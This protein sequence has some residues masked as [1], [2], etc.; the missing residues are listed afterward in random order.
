MPK[1]ISSTDLRNGYNEVS[2]WCHHTNEPAFVTKNGAGDLAVMSMAAYDEMQMRLSLYDFIETG[3]KDV[4]ARH[5]V[6]AR[7]HF[8]QLREKYSLQ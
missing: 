7:S 6:S 1:V 5:V 8:D 3:R 2:A 4:L